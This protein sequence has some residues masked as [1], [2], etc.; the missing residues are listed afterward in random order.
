MRVADGSFPLRYH[1]VFWSRVARSFGHY[2]KVPSQ[3]NG[4]A[5][6]CQDATAIFPVVKKIST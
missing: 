4:M 2:G 5:E 6:I 3:L 1:L